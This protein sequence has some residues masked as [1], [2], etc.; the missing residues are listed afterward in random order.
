MPFVQLLSRNIADQV[1]QPVHREELIRPQIEGFATL[2]GHDA[3]QTFHAV[4]DVHE[5]ASLPAV[6]P[7]FDGVSLGCQRYLPADRRG[8]FLAS[9]FVGAQRPVYVVEAYDARLE[10]IV[11]PEVETQ[12]FREELLPAVAGFWIGGEGV[13]LFECRDLGVVLFALGIDARRRGEE[14]LPQ[15]VE[16]AGLQH[17][18][19]DEDVVAG[20]VRMVGGNEADPAH[21]GAQVKHLVNIARCL[22]AIVP[23]AEVQ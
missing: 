3:Q 19:V 14:E 5:R 21:V 9:T 18:G 1:H 16:S 15:A 8:G 20:H 17:V 2:G 22:H 11:S 12:L 7:D 10:A 13:L 23:F 4:A 6:A